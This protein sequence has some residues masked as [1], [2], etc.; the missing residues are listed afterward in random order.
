MYS[1]ERFFV[2]TARTQMQILET[3]SAVPALSHM[4]SVLDKIK[5]AA[6]RVEA[7]GVF[8]AA[9][10]CQDVISR[11]KSE[12]ISPKQASSEENSKL[13]QS[14]ASLNS[15]IGQYSEGLFE[16]DPKFK[17]QLLAEAKPLA[18][19]VPVPKND[20]TPVSEIPVSEIP[21]SEIDVKSSGLAA[22]CLKLRLKDQHEAAIN[23]L[24]PLMHLV[25]NETQ[26]RALET[27]MRPAANDATLSRPETGISIPQ[28]QTV[29]FEN[30]M[31]P[32][33]NL[34]LSEARYSSKSVSISY[35]ADFDELALELADHVQAFLEILCLNI[36]IN[37]IGDTASQISL[38]GQERDR[39]YRF[40]VNWSGYDMA[41]T[42]EKNSYFRGA[43]IDL[44]AI[45]GS[46]KFRSLALKTEMA[47]QTEDKNTL[48]ALEISFPLTIASKTPVRLHKKRDT[49]S[50]SRGNLARVGGASR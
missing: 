38:T 32:I 22:V 16:I 14:L 28:R 8:R 11:A 41:V 50:V 47:T 35:A 49:K 20:E 44:Q 3:E 48:Q 1:A 19:G 23:T 43:I 33:T 37:G 45:G 12:Q 10:L 36:V 34:I 25:K 42:A 29:K 9:G 5:T 30:L 2:K 40:Y 15:L 31:R 18:A 6:T 27:L 24:K 7:R 4:V 17:K 39:R 13:S 46:I 26:L 21:I